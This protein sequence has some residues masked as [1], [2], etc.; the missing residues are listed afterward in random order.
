MMRAPILGQL[1]ERFAL[2]RIDLIADEQPV[3]TGFS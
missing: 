2:E 1:L 3:V